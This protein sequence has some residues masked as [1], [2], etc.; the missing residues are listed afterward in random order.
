MT[1]LQADW[2]TLWCRSCHR[3]WLADFNP[4]RFHIIGYWCPN[5]LE[6]A[7]RTAATI[8]IVA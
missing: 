1:P 2:Y 8:G 3:H 5:C 4:H 7:R 6:K